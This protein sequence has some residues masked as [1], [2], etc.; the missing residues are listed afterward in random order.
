MHFDQRGVHA[1]P[2]SVCTPGQQGVHSRPA[3]TDVGAGE[4]D[5][6]CWFG[7]QVVLLI[8]KCTRSERAALVKALYRT[9]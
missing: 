7:V 9:T 2:V 4:S 3:P 6:A 1:F 8:E 5:R